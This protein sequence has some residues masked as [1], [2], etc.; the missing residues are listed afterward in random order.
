M[1]NEEVSFDGTSI[2]NKILGNINP[3]NKTLLDVAQEMLGDEK[4]IVFTVR[5][6][7]M[8]PDPVKLPPRKESPRRCH[9]FHDATGFAA[10]ISKYKTEDTVIMA[11]IPNEVIEATLD[12]KAK[13][14]FETVTL[15][16]ITHPL[17][18]PWVPVIDKR[19]NMEIGAFADFLTVNRRAIA[20]PEGKELIAILS[21][22]KV[23]K[24]ITIQ[25]GFG[26]HAVNSIMCELDIMGET[27]SEPVELPD[28]IK[29]L[30][31][32]YVSTTPEIIE[33][34]LTIFADDQNV[35][36]RCSSADLIEK[37]IR[38]FEEMLTEVR[39]IEG[40]IIT[41]GSG[42]NQDWEYLERP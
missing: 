24:K 42:S 28:T 11:N 16:P 34:D 40:V 27:K 18:M 4:H 32:L 5:N 13:Y 38:A 21:Q 8:Q 6:Q 25:R 29:L 35:Y 23:S 9:T 10:Y 7:Q 2:I 26:V 31:P 20:E 33:V 14:G 1:P 3:Q 12:E 39:S 15:E 22:I 30:L 19:E 41:L 36:V 17:F 37:R